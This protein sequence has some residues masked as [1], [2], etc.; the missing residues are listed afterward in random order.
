MKFKEFGNRNNE[1]IIIL[2]GGGLSAW[3]VEPI[4]NYLVDDYYIITPI[5]DG[6]GEDG[7]N[8]FI[9]INESAKNLI[10]Y[11][12]KKHSGKVKALCGLSIGDKL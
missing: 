7:S 1:T 4:V 10:N 11:I 6:H 9:S 3:A 12:D 2:H 8:T 5:I